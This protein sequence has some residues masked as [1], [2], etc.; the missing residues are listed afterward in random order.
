MTTPHSG[1]YLYKFTRPRGVLKMGLHI[2]MLLIVFLAMVATYCQAVSDLTEGKFSASLAMAK[3][4][5]FASLLFIPLL[6]FIGWQ[7]RMKGGR[8]GLALHRAKLALWPLILT[9]LLWA[10]A[11]SLV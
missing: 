7:G 8:K 1:S 9:G 10:S 6:P 3:L 4:A 5:F 11:A 2:W